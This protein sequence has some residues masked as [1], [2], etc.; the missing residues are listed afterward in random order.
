MADNQNLKQKVL[1]MVGDF[2]SDSKKKSAKAEKE[3]IK[4]CEPV[5][6]RF[7]NIASKFGSPHKDFDFPF[8]YMD[9]RGGIDSFVDFEDLTLT[10][11]YTDCCRGEHYTEFPKMPL[12]WLD[13]NAEEEYF[14][15]CKGHAL[16]KK[17]IEIE[18]LKEDYPR[19]LDALE[20]EYKEIEMMTNDKS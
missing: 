7:Y 9:S 17:G 19:K 15:F 6:Q 4:I 16:H 13:D 5:I 3:L 8:D 18:K 11:Q 12:S 20:R 14:R 10:F 1:Q 2:K